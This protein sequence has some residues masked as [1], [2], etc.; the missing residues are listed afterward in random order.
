VAG[1][2]LPVAAVSFMTMFDGA[3]V[4]L[5]LPTLRD[6]LGAPVDEVHWVMTA[7]L[8]LSSSSLLQ[9]GRLGDVL[10]RER[11]WRLGVL[12]FVA[13]SAGATVMP[14][15]W[16][17]VAARAVQGLGAGLATATSAAILVDAFP[18]QRG[19]MLGLGNIAIALGLVAGPPFGA[20][21]TRIV[22]WRLIF[23]VAVPVGLA[24]WLVARRTLPRAERREAPLDW[25]AGVLSFL[26]LGAGLVG[27][28][29]GE[30]WG[31]TSPATL[32]LLGAGLAAIALFFVVQ[33]RTRTPLLERAHLTSRMFLSGLIATFL[34]F[35]ALFTMT[36]SMPFYLL[37][38]QGRPTIG[39]GLLVGVVPLAVSVVAP[40]AGALTD[41]LGSRWICA[42]ALALV[43]IALA[44]LMTGGADASTARIVVA[45][46]L[47]GAGFGGFEAPNDVDILSSLPAGRLGAGSALLNAVRTVGMTLGTALGGT[48][49]ASGMR[50][51]VGTEAARAE[52]GVE[53]ALAAGAFFAVTGTIAAAL[54]PGLSRPAPR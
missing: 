36:I 28:S 42:A 54:R 34:G 40:I 18:G 19:K 4:Q 2:L 50:A 27:G 20:I 12:L 5:A 21:L 32:A 29:F 24:A 38:V 30:R 33:A 39:T 41:R 37:V 53:L 48:L 47:I 8:L 43:A 6:D 1:V 44:L 17:L 7:F 3:A 11:V 15:L 31:W 16:S 26:G 23:A 52:H 13:A 49:I 35:A 9:A 22:S 10:G 25:S 14:G 46:A 45:L 51:A